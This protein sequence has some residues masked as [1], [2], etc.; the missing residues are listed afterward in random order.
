MGYRRRRTI[1]SPRVPSAP[2]PQTP[3]LTPKAKADADGI[4]RADF[5]SVSEILSYI[6]GV[7]QTH[8]SVSRHANYQFDP[9]TW[10]ETMDMLKGGWPEGVKEVAFNTDKINALSMRRQDTAS[11]MTRLGITSTSA[12]SSKGRRSASGRLSRR[13]APR[14]PSR[15][16]H[17]RS[18][19]AAFIRIVS[20]I[21]ALRSAP[22]S[23]SSGKPIL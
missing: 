14:T 9:F 11:S 22:L 8:H 12:R 13:K 15:S 3:E 7:D 20:E 1:P 16:S 2:A 5:S 6:S 18:P 17:R 10:K 23:T 19:H 21:G 4:V